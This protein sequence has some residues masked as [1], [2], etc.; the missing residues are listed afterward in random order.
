M[1]KPARQYCLSTA[2]TTPACDAMHPGIKH[3][4]TFFGPMLRIWAFF[5]LL[6]GTLRYLSVAA[7]HWSF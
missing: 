3:C 1:I 6:M 5:Q 2:F 7:L 4:S